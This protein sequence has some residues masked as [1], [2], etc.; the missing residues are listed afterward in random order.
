MRARRR[1][2]MLALVSVVT[3]A[4]AAQTAPSSTRAIGCPA[5]T[6]WDNLLQRC[7]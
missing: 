3:I 5:S 6:S 7:V 1:R 4:L 2:L